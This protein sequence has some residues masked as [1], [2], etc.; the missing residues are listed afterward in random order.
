MSIGPGTHIGPY[1][2][3][4]R[5]GEGGMGIVYRA[6]DTQL[7]REVAL[8][9]LPD[10]FA[11]DSDRLERFQRE[12][13]LLAALNHPNI[14]HIYGLERVGSAGCIVMELVGG[15]TLA[16]RIKRG[17]VPLDDALQIARQL[18]DA[19]EAAH[20][21][22]II[23][24][25][26]KPANI[27]L[28]T[29]GTVKV[30]D[31]GL[32][33]A[34]GGRTDADP[35]N[36]PTVLSGSVPGV[37]MGTA[38][39]MSP[40]QARG[41]T[42]DA[43]TDIW[44]FGCVLYE[45]LTARRA[46]DG[47]TA[48]DIVAKIIQGEPQWDRLPAD[49][50]PSI[51]TL[52]KILLSKDP[53]QRLQHIGDVRVLSNQTLFQQT[54][55]VAVAPVRT[56]G[57][58]LW[59]VR[60]AVSVA[61]LA[62]LVPASLYFLRA[63]EEASEIRFEMPAPGIINESLRVSP[64]GQRVAYVAI[65]NGKREVWVRSIGALSAQPLPGTENAMNYLLGW[66]PDSRRLG[67]F[68]DG[69]LKKID[70]AGG[71][72]VAIARASVALPG[73]WNGK[74]DILFSTRHESSALVIVRVSDSGGDV[75]AMTT[76]DLSSKEIAHVAPTFLPDG[77]RFL[78]FRPTS[79]AD[80]QWEIV[81]Y[82]GSLDSKSAT[83]LRS[84]G[85]Y[86]PNSPSG[87]GSPHVYVSP[88]YWL[89]LVNG[90]LVAE[91]M[92]ADGT[93]TG[94]DPVRIADNIAGFSASDKLLL[95]RQAAAGT[96]TGQ[97]SFNRLV[98]FD[99]SGK[100]GASAGDPA[101]YISVD[102]SPDDRRAIVTRG[103]GASNLDL[104][105]IDIDRGGQDRLTSHSGLDFHPVW[106]PDGREIAFTSQV[107]NP[108]Q[109]PSLYRRS[110]ISVGGDT[111]LVRSDNPIEASFPQDWSPDGKT[112]VFGR[113]AGPTAPAMNIW[114]MTLTDGG[115]PVPYL[116]SQSR[117]AQAQLSPDGRWLA[118]ATTESGMPQIVVQSFPDPKTAKIVVTR[119]GGTEPRWRRD[120]RELFYISPDGRL[121]AVPVKT[122]DTFE[123]GTESA[124]FQTPL[125]AGGVGSVRRYD[126]AADGK[127]FLIISPL[128]GASSSS[129]ADSM[130]ITAV[131]NWTAALRKK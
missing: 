131:V 80:S 44:A 45:M 107:G 93:F 94:D 32:A 115:K 77:R 65:T 112:I 91:R 29:D 10:H 88:G 28:T 8:K 25:D 39:Y 31:F 69:M 119:N 100:Q 74:G 85:P 47:E 90:T 55:P 52:L 57:R 22:G 12:A 58:R 66:A 111:L 13:Q 15:E 81:L 89:G 121:M 110:S 40:E 16:E 109:A 6:L 126:V 76:M 33:K 86:D 82:A 34:L 95:Y 30:L 11:G 125:V 48:T 50:P 61:F 24:R 9:V 1:E 103:A 70:I 7:Q 43:R 122:S 98:W 97:D 99:R 79:A 18:A 67:F 59:L 72:P 53:K 3:T 46:F 35:S 75:T 20:A 71:P 42:V 63:P 101:S 84:V 129:N 124:L 41:K 117:K 54:P 96:P 73:A 114:Y 108:V 130:P 128:A 14:G 36:S 23:H 51:R 105:T 113:Q 127:R 104:W 83:R 87:T 64:D 78:Y 38:A 60:A 21:Q 116:E 19:L 17:P 62:A 27:K 37:I 4:S 5:I 118:Y 120:G 49:V 68:A 102:L 2:V 106:A 56:A 92:N 26:L 123:L